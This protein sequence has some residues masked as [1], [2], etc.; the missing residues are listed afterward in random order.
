MNTNR[1]VVF[2]LLDLE[3]VCMVPVP[4]KSISAKALRIE[5]SPSSSRVSLNLNNETISII[6]RRS[7]S[8]KSS[9]AIDDCRISLCINEI[10]P[11]PTSGRFHL[12]Y[13]G[14]SRLS[15]LASYRSEFPNH[16]Y[17][18]VY[19]FRL[20]NHATTRQSAERF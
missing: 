19:D 11:F 8:A 20:F 13:K 6:L 12:T 15:E 17:Y 1:L 18:L 16:Q 2:G 9:Q 10:Y 5:P 3:R 7:S 14:D 4:G